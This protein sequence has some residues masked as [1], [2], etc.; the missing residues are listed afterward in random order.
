MVDILVLIYKKMDTV[1][2]HTFMHNKKINT[3]ETKW[4]RSATE[5][6]VKEANTFI[7]QWY[8]IQ[9]I[10]S[11]KIYLQWENHVAIVCSKYNFINQ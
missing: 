9:R 7:D 3:I 8:R 5:E 4:R 2:V 11:W 1:Y 6:Q 10:K